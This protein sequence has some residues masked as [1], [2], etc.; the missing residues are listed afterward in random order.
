MKNIDDITDKISQTKIKK[1]DL[2]NTPDESEADDQQPGKSSSTKEDYNPSFA[3]T[4]SKQRS[5]STKVLSQTREDFSLNTDLD[6]PKD[7]ISD[8][9]AMII[10]TLDIESDADES[11]VLQAMLNAYHQ[12]RRAKTVHRNLQ[13]SNSPSGFQRTPISGSKYGNNLLGQTYI[14]TANPGNLSIATL[15]VNLYI[16]KILNGEDPPKTKKSR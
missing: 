9:Q 16:L 2:T 15:R 10:T 11:E 13:Q 6:F 12:E 8:L 14:N 4:G 3:V 7:P 5:K 1:A